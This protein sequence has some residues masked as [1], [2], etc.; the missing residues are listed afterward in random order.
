MIFADFAA[1]DRVF[2]DANPLVYHFAPHPVFGAAARQM[3][4][5][6]ENQELEA[7]TSTHVLSEVAHHLMTIEATAVFGWTSKV[8]GHLK[9]QPASVQQ[10]SSFR[11]AV[12]R[13][14]QSGIQVLTISPH[15]I[16]MAAALS[17]QN[18]LL[19]NDALIVAVMQVHGLTKIAS[20]DADFDRAPGITRYAP[21]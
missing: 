18:G 1:N 17:Q 19:S 20:N 5:R 14:L 10:L 11:R 2:L 16:A 15:L 12:E 6:I 9:Q 7:F 13:I 4:K 8:V 21:V 3:I